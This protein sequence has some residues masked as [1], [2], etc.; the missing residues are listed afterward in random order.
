MCAWHRT[1]T[2][3]AHLGSFF[4]ALMTSG[5]FT[6]PS[7]RSSRISIVECRST[8]PEYKGEGVYCDTIVWEN[9]C[10]GEGV[11]CDTIDPARV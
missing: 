1:L 10:K 2:R 7:R 9:T 8:P 6:V 4:S 3:V 5:S 11:Y